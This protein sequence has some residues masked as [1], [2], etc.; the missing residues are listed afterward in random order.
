MVAP[1]RYTSQ[2]QQERISRRQLCERLDAFGWIA[3]PPDEDL[4]E[5][6]I[7]HIYLQGRAT[8]VTF[9]LQL[10][11]V[12]N[13]NERRKGDYLVYDFEVK[14]LKHWEA[15][16]LPVV[17]M[18][19]D[20]ELREGRWALVDEVIS[21]L[22]QRRPRWRNNKSKASVYIPWNNRTDD[23]G[24]IQL[25]K[26]IGRYFYPFIAKKREPEVE[27]GLDFPDTKE[28]QTAL[29]DF[30]NFLRNGGQITI[31]GEF[32]SELSL[33]EW[34]TLW[35]GEFDRN[36]LKVIIEFP[37]PDKTFPVAVTM[38]SNN[39]KTVSIPNIELKVIRYGLES[40]ELSNQHQNSPLHFRYT[41]PK[42]D[43]KVFIK[44]NNLGSDI[45]TVHNTANFLQ[46]LADGGTLRFTFL[47][48][49]KIVSQNIVVS[50]QPE[51]KF[52]SAYLTLID[53]LCL[54]Q[55]RT[56]QFLPVPD[57]EISGKEVK[58]INRVVEIIERG[59]TIIQDYE[60]KGEF[61]D[62]ALK[63][64][65]NAFQNNEPVKVQA[66]FDGSLAKVLGIEIQT[67][68]GTR[69]ST[70]RPKLPI[71]ESEKVT[72]EFVD[73][74]IIDV[75]LDWYKKEA[76]RLSQLLAER[77]EVEAVYLFG[78]LVWS[79][80]HTPETDIDLAVSG[81]PEERFLD[82]VSYLERE[83][84]FPIDLIDLSKASDH[85]RQRILAEGK[86]LYE[87]EPVA[88]FG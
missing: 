72:V 33:P 6:F 49:K 15:F 61:E 68:P 66:S 70:G 81:L 12:T 46:A 71:T 17:L 10:K 43:E 30:D 2:K 23:T 37:I 3:T 45:Y 64:I 88:A 59:K 50:P 84:K 79:D 76:Q 82:A 8:G 18:V 41:I 35:F 75:F 57:R 63:L 7:V 47:T 5:D 83:S 21:D 54:I 19:W 20:I 62:E 51:K 86:L 87:R 11:S 56:G 65:L 28:G 80:I 77:F 4:G 16:S 32:V 25:K 53:K 22:D 44:V 40:A 24:L 1:V 36:K 69:W 74:E 14:D 55:N 73:V 60:M 29:A 13:L 48:L 85:L 78:S 58:E 52:N 34:Y 38:L 9:H 67:G 39:G 27:I 31:E 42:S 26:S